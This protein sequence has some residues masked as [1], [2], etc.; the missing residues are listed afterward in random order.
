VAEHITGWRADRALGLPLDDV[1][2][3]VDAAGNE[4]LALG[5][6][7][8]TATSHEAIGREV[9]IVRL[10]GARIGVNYSAAPM[11]NRE[12]GLAGSVLT[13]RDVSAER[14]FAKRR[15][16]EASHDVLTGLANRREFERRL[17][18]AL[19]TARGEDRTHVVCF[20]DLDRFKVV[21]DTCGHAA[22]DELLKGIT[23]LMRS[24]VR[25][26]DT[27]ARLGGDEFALLLDGCSV[28]RAQHIAGDLLAAVR[29]YRFD[30]KFKTLGVGL[31]VGLAPMDGEASAAEVM[32]MADTACYWA[33]EQGRDRVCVYNTGDGDMA[34]RRREMSW[35]TRINA[36]L[37]QDRFVLYHQTYLALNPALEERQHVEVLLRM[38]DEEGELVQPGSFL[39][40]AERYNLMPAID[41]WVIK[42]VFDGYRALREERGGTPL[43]CAI[44]LSGTSLNSEGL[45]DFI[46][47][48]AKANELPPQS[49]CFEI[50]ETAAINNLRNAAEFIRQCKAMG[51]LFALD[52]FGTG[53]SSFGYLKNLPV[54][55][56]KIDGG[57]VKNIERDRID[58]AMTETINH[59]GHIL[60]IRTVAE[61]A[62]NDS[63][64]KQLRSMGVDYAQGYGVHRP[65]PLFVEAVADTL[66]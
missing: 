24:R 9:D 28:E 51:F 56:L 53:T 13:F 65:A 63:I 33:K 8:I 46:R 49:I 26:S 25:E 48:H 54:D 60:G 66:V 52:D 58:R 18:I 7:H 17:E 31:S 3:L 15:S 62:E 2:M 22:G 10:D 36:A 38:I 1:L 4:A 40:A 20:M 55:Y 34:A 11:H 43:T 27:L 32:S 44:N 30:W 6:A 50:T 35:V 64:I 39:P 47:K 5:L 16:W 37:E 12:G 19:D 59:V 57:F 61:Y 45:I 29:D 14:S 42:R 21:N 23:D 41:S